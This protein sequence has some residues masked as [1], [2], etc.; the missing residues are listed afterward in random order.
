MEYPPENGE[1]WW[2]VDL[3]SAESE[4]RIPK[5]AITACIRDFKKFKKGTIY[6]VFDSPDEGWVT[7]LL[8]VQPFSFP[9][10]LFARYFDAE[11]F[12]R[13][14]KSI[15]RSFNKFA[16]IPIGYPQATPRP[17]RVKDTE[18]ITKNPNLDIKFGD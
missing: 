14:R 10:Y 17:Y 7:V 2:I 11:I 4:F 1:K 5:D 3:N 18:T 9:Q 15:P 6:K 8:G 13:G 12:I 16:P